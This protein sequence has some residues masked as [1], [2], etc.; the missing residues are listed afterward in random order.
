MNES[1][2]HTNDPL[3]HTGLPLTIMF[4]GEFIWQLIFLIS[5]LFGLS[6]PKNGDVI[7][8]KSKVA[9]A[10]FLI[11]LNSLIFIFTRTQESFTLLNSGVTEFTIYDQKDSNTWGETKYPIRGGISDSSLLIW[12]RKIINISKRCLFWNIWD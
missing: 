12:I 5:K 11:I 7:F 1:C 2:Y 4:N 9:S 8:W 3:S 10:N 6:T